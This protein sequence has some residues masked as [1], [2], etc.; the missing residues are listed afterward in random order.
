[1][2]AVFRVFDR[3]ASEVRALKRVTLDGDSRQ[4]AIEAFELEYQVLASLDHP[5][6]IRVFDYGVDAE[7][8]YYTMELLEGR[9]MRR[10]APVHYKQAC[11]YLRDVATSLVLLHGRRLI[12]RDLSPSNVR[13]TPDGHCKL[14]DFGALAS[15]GRSSRV[16]G[17]PP[18]VAPEALSGTMLDQRTDLFALGALAYWMLTGRHAY[19]A[20]SLAELNTRWGELPP[21]PS[22]LVA[23]I[24]EELDALV[25]ALLKIE[26]LA[27]PG[28]A[29]EV[30]S[31]VNVIGQ[32]PLEDAT[33]TARLAQIFFASPRFT[34]RTPQMRELNRCIDAAVGGE[35]AALRIEAVPGMGRS[36]LLDEIGVRARLSGATVI[37]ADASVS[38]QLQG[39]AQSLVARVFELLPELARELAPYFRTALAATGRRVEPA[40]ATKSSGESLA[41]PRT[42][43]EF[44]ADISARRPLVIAVDNLEDADDA[45]HGLLASLA[46]LAARYPLLLV[47]TEAQSEEVHKPGIGSQALRRHSRQIDLPE[48]SRLELLELSRSIFMDAPNLERFADWLHERSAG[49]P[50]YAIEICRRL[51]AKGVIRYTSGLWSL[52]ADRPDAELPAA[53]GDALTIRIDSLDDESRGL[54]ECLSLQREQPTLK[55]CTL[56]CDEAEEPA[57][58]AR[59]LLDELTRAGV[60][61]ADRGSYRFSSSALRAA[62]LQAMDGERLERNHRRLGEAFSRLA[63]DDDFAMR[64]EA[65]FHLIEGGEELRGAELIAS[66][67]HDSSKF[68]TLVAN[69]YHAGKPVEAAYKV[70]RRVRR[71]AYE[72]LPLLAAL[73]QAGYY[74]DRYF[75]EAYGDEALNLLEEVCGLARARR[76]RRFLGNALAL[77]IGVLLAWLRF[78][79]TPRQQRPFRFGEIWLVLFSTVTTLTGTAALSLDAVRADHVAATLEPFAFL[80]ERLTPVGIYQFCRGLGQIPRENSVEAYATFELLLQRFSN[81]RYYPTLPDDGRALMLAAVHFARGSF[82]LFRADASAALES[83]DAL[84]ATGYKLYAMIASSLRFLYFA[85]R[86]EFAKAAPHRDQLELHAAHV[87]SLWQVETW[88][89]AALILIYTLAIGDVV[90][91]TRVMHRLEGI[92]RN[93]PSLKRYSRLAHDA[94]VSTHHDQRFVDKIREKH[95][96]DEPREFIGWAATQSAVVRSLND[97]GE[98]T[99]ARAYSADVLAHV[100]DA[101]RDLVALFL[102]LDIQVAYADAGLGKIDDALARIDGLIARFSRCNHPLLQGLL[103]ETRAYICWEAKHLDAYRFSLAQT[104]RWFRPTGTPALIAKCERL[105]D[106][107]QTTK[108]Q[109]SKPDSHNDNDVDSEADET[110]TVVEPTQS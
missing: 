65:G 94:L 4:F 6:I 66:V 73:A 50:L 53:L 23:G 107:S 2:G 47:V 24:P 58:R 72:R 99:K 54:A 95:M 19:P 75:G 62:L 44:F 87:G 81:P 80:P 26:P 36:R 103:H 63:S 9:D 110:E 45:S 78:V 3:V 21:A 39:T 51:H 91:A 16:V 13:I 25:S 82:A 74:E 84:E 85:A 41:P 79:L 43:A 38:R 27:R 18:M 17:T 30:I 88:E 42:L 96:L 90:G 60:L 35:G 11:L 97:I 93:V 1:M 32:L 76:L 31:R 86:G 105:A 104:E 109:L 70:Y 108:M 40:F 8:P 29:A 22:S 64:I 71:T 61:A 68:R 48:L 106:I 37:A 34:G 83:A 28:S 67:T 55:L 59:D 14:L 5:R 102:P 98:F 15:F 52:P 20:R 56:L 57:A 10:A 77:V 33:Q 100:T 49:S 69:L 46:S 89:A 101:D 12:H 7:G 92:S